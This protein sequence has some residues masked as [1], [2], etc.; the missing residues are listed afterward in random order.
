MVHFVVHFQTLGGGYSGTGPEQLG[1]EAH[2]KQLQES[3][4][5]DS[6]YIDTGGALGTNAPHGDGSKADGRHGG[7]VY[8]AAGADR[9]RPPGRPAARPPGGIEFQNSI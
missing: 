2:P 5:H 3:R 7:P 8:Q 1:P 6:M 9:P 4:Y